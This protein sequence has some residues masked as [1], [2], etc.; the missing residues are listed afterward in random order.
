MERTDT[1]AEH[2]KFEWIV[3]DQTRTDVRR[4][5][6]G[7]G[8][9]AAVAAVAV[10]I[11]VTSADPGEDPSSPPIAQAA[12]PTRTADLAAA[13]GL[14]A[15]FVNHDLDAAASYLAPGAQPW[16]GWK[17]AW[18]RDAAY[19]VEYLMEPCAQAYTI[20]DSTVV[21]TCPYAMHLLGSGEVGEGPYRDNVLSV[22]VTDGKVRWAD[23]TMPF[24]TNGMAEHYDAVHTWVADNHPQAYKHFLVKDEQDVTPAEWPKW[25]RLWKQYIKE[26]VAAANQTR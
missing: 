12:G 7:G 24:E 18:K 26:Y 19:R 5:W 4:R 23:S 22:T 3:A 11:A 10:A 21:F 16:A 2:Q 8:V 17:A 20:A 1:L 9:A 13:E 25:A 15:A 14:A 6:I